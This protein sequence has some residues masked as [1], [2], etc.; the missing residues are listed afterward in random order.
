MSFLKEIEEKKSALKK[1]EVVKKAEFANPILKDEE[2]YYRLL[3]ETYFED[4]YDLIKDFTFKSDIR[5][6]S[7]EEIRTVLQANKEFTETGSSDTVDLT[8]V[9]NKIDESIAAIREVTGSEC[10]VFVRFSSR[11]PKDA[12]YLLEAFPTLIQEKLQ[13]LNSTDIY[14]KLHAFYMASTEILAISSGSEAV[15][16]FRK[17]SRIVGD[18][19]HCLE[20]SEPMNLIVREFVQFP[21]KNELRGFVYQGSLTALTQY[22]R[23]CYFPDQLE[24]KAE[25]EEKVHTFMEGFIDAMRSLLESFVVDIV[26]DTA[27]QVR[28]VEVNPFGELADSCLFSWTKDR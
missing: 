10:K 22:N 20:V 8:S 12:I 3:R 1:A 14:A 4:Y 16:L 24:T 28:V 17:S 2:D 5:I 13:E 27:G 15:D 19:E 11:S 26:V 25:V 18:L 7:L 23:T 9:K 6:L 21:V